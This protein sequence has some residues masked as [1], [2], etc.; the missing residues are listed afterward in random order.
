VVERYAY[1]AYGEPKLL[2]GTGTVLPDS[3]KDNR[4]TY[5][6]REWDKAIGL[7]HFRARMYDSESGRFCGRDPL[8]TSRTMLNLYAGQFAS[9]FAIDPGG[10]DWVWPWDPNADWVWPFEGMNDPQFVS[11]VLNSICPYIQSDITGCVCCAIEVTDLTAALAGLVL[12]REIPIIDESL[13]VLDCLCDA[14]DSLNAVCAVWNGTGSVSTA[15]MM[16]LTATLSCMWNIV[17]IFEVTGVVA[18]RP[19][20]FLEIAMAVVQAQ[21]T[22][23]AGCHPCPCNRFL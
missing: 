12:P 18:D 7:Y 21:L 13:N 9:K 2:S 8:I 3:A 5:T 22:N 1:S 11:I 23:A 20:F 4:Y 19:G 6:G 15:L 17:D 14:G 16:N 10:N